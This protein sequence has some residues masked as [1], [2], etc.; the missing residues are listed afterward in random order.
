MGRRD[1]IDGGDPIVEQ[2]K[3]R[4]KIFEF[5]S[6]GQKENQPSKAAKCFGALRPPP[7]SWSSCSFHH[8][9][10]IVLSV[11]RAS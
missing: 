9:C 6:L 7:P 3:K 1:L 2:V 8:A 4:S 10:A 5:V 11:K